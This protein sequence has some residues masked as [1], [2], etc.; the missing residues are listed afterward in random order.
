MVKDRTFAS[1]L[2]DVVNH[3]LLA[4]VA[5]A[6]LLPIIHMIAVSFSDRASTTAGVV[7]F[8][9]VHYNTVNYQR[10]FGDPQFLR[11]GG[12]SLVRVLLGTALQVLMV[13]VTAYPLSLPKSFPGQAAY[14]W[15]LIFCMMFSGGLIPWY[16]VLRM[17]HLTNNIWGLVLPGMLSLWEVIIM[18]NFFRDMPPEISEA[19]E[20]DGASHWDILFR[21][22]VPLS[23][24]AIAMVTLFSAVNHW[25]SWFDGLVL[26]ND[27]RNYPLQSYLQTMI[28]SRDYMR[29]LKNAKTIA[30]LSERSLRAAQIIIATVPIVAIYPVLQR[31]FVSGLK[32][33]SVKG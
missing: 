7:A 3:V 11:S 19:A 21:I 27:T 14:R 33:G 25:N 20:I 15:L 1:L 5:L 29:L 8:W 2:F 4:L 23:L 18:V 24:P 10:V 13:I 9:P 26:M 32:L 30:M 12:I 16:L 31:Y 17:L 28:V 6:C 22:Y